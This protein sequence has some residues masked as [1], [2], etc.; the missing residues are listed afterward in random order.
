[1]VFAQ[2]FTRQGTHNNIT[3]AKAN[4]QVYKQANKTLY[5]NPSVFHE[6]GHSTSI[7]R[8]GRELLVEGSG[9]FLSHA[10]AQGSYWVRNPVS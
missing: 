4:K 3:M 9:P 8:L 1:M 7:L 2:T 5:K 6:Y 10:R